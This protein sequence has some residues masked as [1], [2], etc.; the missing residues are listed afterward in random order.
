MKTFNDFTGLEGV[1][2]LIECAPYV[3]ELLSDKE[4]LAKMSEMTWIELGA[5]MYKAHTEACDRLFEV[6]DAKPDTSIGLVSATAQI[7]A[8]IFSNKDMID[9]FI[10]ASKAKKSSFSVTE[11]TV[12]EQ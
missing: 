9:F 10:S 3:G 4:N 1:D 11:N 6:L 7:M 12:E 5:T 2:K 8:E